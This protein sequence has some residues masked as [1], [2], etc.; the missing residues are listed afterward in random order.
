M[1]LMTIYVCWR[2]FFRT[3]EECNTRVKLEHCEFMQEE[4]EYLG[5]QVGWRWWRPVK[6]IV[7]P[8]LMACIR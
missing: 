7:T 5:F 2:K 8:N 6:E 4:I 1:T 3:C